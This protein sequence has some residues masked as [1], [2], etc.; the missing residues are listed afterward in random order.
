MKS[1]RDQL[2]G[3]VEHYSNKDGGHNSSNANVDHHSKA[4][5]SG[6]YLTNEYLVLPK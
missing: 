5:T 2:H 4:S 3:L 6:A 1:N